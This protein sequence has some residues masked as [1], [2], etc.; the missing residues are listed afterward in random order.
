[1]SNTNDDIEYDFDFGFHAVHENDI[2]AVHEVNNLK[3]IADGKSE[4]S[5]DDLIKLRKAI[6]P[7]LNNLR[8][9]PEK[10]YIFWPD[11]LGKVDAFE[12]H[13]DKICEG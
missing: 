2:E 11:R 3:D 13:I 6:Q 1:M 5:A 9:N 12:A 10:D 8:A 7:L 4:R